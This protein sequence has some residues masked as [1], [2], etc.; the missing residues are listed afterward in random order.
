MNHIYLVRHDAAK[1]KHRLF[2]KMF[3]AQGLL[4]EWSLMWEWGRVGSPGTVRKDC[5]DT[6]EEAIIARQTLHDAK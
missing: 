2:Y 4:G 3:M 6:E 1:N 5:F